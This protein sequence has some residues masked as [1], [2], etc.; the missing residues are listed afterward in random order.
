MSNISFFYVILNEKSICSIILVI[1][2]HIQGL[3]ID[4]KVRNVKQYSQNIAFAFNGSDKDVSVN[5][6]W[7]S[8]INV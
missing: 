6:T 7:L 5:V 3:K 2:G 4:S 8:N 1:Q